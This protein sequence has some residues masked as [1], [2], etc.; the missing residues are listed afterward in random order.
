M[1]K[2]LIL[3]LLCLAIVVAG[4]FFTKHK[5]DDKYQATN[6]NIVFDKLEQIKQLSIKSSKDFHSA[7]ILKSK[8]DDLKTTLIENQTISN[9]AAETQTYWVK[10]AFSAVFCLAALFVV[11]SNKY[12]ADTKKWAFSVLSLISGIWI[13]SIK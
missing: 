9:Q 4:I 10:V 1:S 2:L 6:Q 5:L 7:G 13:G 11:L 3:S 12:D 8:S